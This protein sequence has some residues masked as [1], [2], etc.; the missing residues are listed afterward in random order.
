MCLGMRGRDLLKSR[1]SVSPTGD[2]VLYHPLEGFPGVRATSMYQ[3][4]HQLF[5]TTVFLVL[6][7]YMFVSSHK[8]RAFYFL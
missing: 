4:Y 8:N 7:I 3:T 5:I 2:G 1:N 6:S